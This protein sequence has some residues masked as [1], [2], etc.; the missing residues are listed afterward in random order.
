[1]FLYQDLGEVLMKRSLVA[2]VDGELWDMHRPLQK[3]CT[4]K[5]FHVKT[6]DAQQ[7]FL[8][9]KTFWRSCR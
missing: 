4:L 1:M 3:D 9:N 8:V 5:F 7:A 6:T 2:E